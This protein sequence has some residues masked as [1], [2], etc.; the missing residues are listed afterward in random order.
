[1]AA[2]YERVHDPNQII[3][4]VITNTPNGFQLDGSTL[5]LEYLPAPQVTMRLEGRY[6]LAKDPIYNYGDNLKSRQDFFVMAAIA[7]QLK[8]STAVKMRTGT[9]LKDSY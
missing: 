9:G 7:I 2:R 5:T 3:N 4:E 6:S 8:N 1:M